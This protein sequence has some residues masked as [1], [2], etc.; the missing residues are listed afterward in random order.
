MNVTEEYWE[1]DGQSLHTYAFAIRTLSGREG[2]PP[3]RGGNQVVAYRPG[4]VWRPKVFGPRQLAL[5]MFVVGRDEDDEPGP[6]GPRAQFR[7]NLELLKAL[8]APTDRLLAVTKRMRTN[9]GLLV[10]TGEAEV[11]DAIE[12]NVDAPGRAALVVDLLMPDPFWYGAEVEAAVPLAGATVVNPGTTAV[13]RMTIRLNGPLTNPQLVNTSLSPV[14]AL[15][16]VGVIGV[17]DY[18]DL[19]VG[20][21]R[22]TDQDDVSV[23]GKVSHSGA[24]PWMVLQPGGNS[25]VLNVSAG[26]GNAEIVFSPPYL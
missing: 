8:F 15:S 11:T 9:D 17:G 14:V 25:M 19:D 10:L 2:L 24:W 5:A 26:T 22:A 13:T 12:P 18:V 7:S 3:R 21:F 23:I 4:E 6:N 16:Y 1:V 20:V